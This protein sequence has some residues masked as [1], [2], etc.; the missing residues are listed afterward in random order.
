MNHFPRSQPICCP[1]HPTRELRAA[2]LPGQSGAGKVRC[3]WH[4]A[5]LSSSLSPLTARRS[6]HS[7]GNGPLM[8]AEIPTPGISLCHGW[9]LR[10]AEGQLPQRRRGRGCKSHRGC[11][12]SEGQRRAFSGF[13]AYYQ[14]AKSETSLGILALPLY[15]FLSPQLPALRSHKHIATSD[16]SF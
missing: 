7:T 12:T 15:S 11:G 5:R 2:A 9:V 4:H 14:A 1:P 13:P 6:G 3:Q 10:L 16:E 8:V